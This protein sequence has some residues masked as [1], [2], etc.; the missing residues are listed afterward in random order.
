M[1]QRL[2]L[3]KMLAP[4]L[5]SVNIS[6]VVAGLAPRV[7]GRGCRQGQGQRVFRCVSSVLLTIAAPI[8]V[9]ETS[10]AKA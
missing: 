10:V 3:A 9:L 8:K 1:E 4:V 7:T 6:G 2:R 5:V